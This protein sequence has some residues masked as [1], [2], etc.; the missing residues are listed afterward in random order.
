MA[1]NDDENEEQQVLNEAETEAKNE[2]QEAQNAAKNEDEN[3]E[4]EV[5]N[6]AGK[7]NKCFESCIGCF[8]VV[9]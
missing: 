5:Q 6:A 2:E 7:P 4:Q 3:E 9:Y 1:A 8:I